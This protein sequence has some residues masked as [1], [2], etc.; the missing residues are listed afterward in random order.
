MKRRKKLEIAIILGLLLSQGM[1][2]NAWAE[3]LSGFSTLSKDYHYSTDSEYVVTGQITI[4]NGHTA[5]F[6]NKDGDNPVDNVTLNGGTGAAV[7][8]MA[9]GGKL[10]VNANDAIVVTSD[11]TFYAALSAGVDGTEYSLS[12]GTISISGNNLGSAILIGS[13]S[14]VN[15]KIDITAKGDAD[16]KVDTK[17]NT[18]TSKNSVAT[19]NVSAGITNITAEKGSNYIE[20][21]NNYGRGLYITTGAAKINVT[22]ENGKNIIETGHNAVEIQGDGA[23]I[24]LKGLS[25][26]IYSTNNGVAGV[27]VNRSNNGKITITATG[28]YVKGYGNNEIVGRETGVFVADSPKEEFN[29]V[30]LEAT[31]KNI[32]NQTKEMSDDKT[33][34]AGVYVGHGGSLSMTAREN[35]IK[36]VNEGV[37]GYLQSDITITATEGNNAI[38]AERS[39]IYVND[40][41]SH[42]D[43][44]S[45]IKLIAEKGDNIVQ[46]GKDA[47][48][49][50]GIFARYNS[51]VTLQAQNNIIE[52]ASVDGNR[53]GSGKAIATGLDSGDVV[54]DTTVTLEATEQNY[55]SGMVH[56]VAATTVNL[57]G[58]A[59]A[60]GNQA[61]VYN[62][63]RSSYVNSNGLQAVH[64]YDDAVINIDAGS[65][66]ERYNLIRTMS[67]TFDANNGI[68]RTVWAQRGANINIDGLSYIFAQNS[69]V[70]AAETEI[71]LDALDGNS[72]G[73][74]IT[75]GTG[76]EDEL[77]GYIQDGKL[78]DV[79]DADKSTVNVNYLGNSG[80]IGD[81]VSGFGGLV[82]VISKE[83]DGNLYLS[84]NA[85]AA[86]GG[87]AN[88]ELGVNGTW[89]GR[90]D[91]Y[92][93]ADDGHTTF[94]NPA[95]S[96][97]IID[98]GE[99]NLTMGDNST[100]FV[101][102][103]SWITSIDTTNA[104]NTTID[105]VSANTDHNTTAHALTIGELKGNTIFNMSLDGDRSVSDMLYIKEAHDGEYLVNLA[106]AV[107]TA[108]MYSD[109]VNTFTGLRFA[110]I[111]TGNATFRAVTYDDGFE[112]IEYL[113]AQD[114]YATSNENS[115]YNSADGSGVSNQEKPGDDSVDALFSD[116]AAG[117]N[118][119]NYKLVARKGEE[120]SDA[121]KT[122]LNMSR[123]NYSN[124]VYMDRLNKRLGEARY[125]NDEED[126][127][128]WVRIRHDRIGKTDAYR[129]QNTM[130]ELGYD[131]KQE[132]DNGKRRVGFALDYMHGDTGYDNIAGKG[133][134]DRYGVWLYDTWLGDK[135]HYADYVAKWGHLENDFEIYAPT[136]GEK[137][138]GD[139]CNNVLSISA[140]YGR[141]KD[142]GKD[143]YI[144]PQ[145][146]LQ[147][148]H[149]TDAGYTTSQNTAVQVDSINSLI[150]RLGFRLGKD[151]G[152]EKRSTVY[153]K[154]DILHEF[155]GDQDIHAMDRTTNGNWTTVS[156]ENKGTWYDVGFGYAAMLNK[157]SYAFIDLE[158]SF[159]HDNDE[160]YQINAGVQWSF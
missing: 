112:D 37:E 98:N 41:Y 116:S 68:E 159:G 71:D 20:N 32:I 43:Y 58:L 4:R 67:D 56:A 79:A 101:Q 8:A 85:L 45:N 51:E 42:D 108:E 130:Y 28:D 149:V 12:A 157:D 113:I 30:I 92:G 55:L 89:Y 9:G 143:W 69:G 102:G 117:L 81:I 19:V 54:N 40:K 114:D 21:T 141:K 99:V 48:N 120:L 52:A 18:L 5:E 66:K 3:N 106:D 38:N 44:M 46:A 87:I 27:Y 65:S 153:V 64:G 139:Y 146:Q 123:A 136:T 88:I 100:W 33:S 60:D 22:A 107:T 128:M 94:F 133:E 35:E 135:G 1:Y 17:V 23:E 151:F 97:Q 118:A 90:A 145:A 104:V 147:F 6:G 110:T 59:D 111:G 160:T 137:I 78:P 16:T 77:D 96:S 105:L 150:G 155:L 72:T 36:A 122:V 131:E 132:C 134:I 119:T 25:N 142:M 15:N 91:D 115:Y 47:N 49:S 50:S 127:G 70:S 129:S 103:Q 109:G 39:G 121:G 82:N 125:I 14:A 140:E 144:E 126:E 63:I 34:A 158:R 93:D 148:A 152:E 84:G 62:I 86:N 124:A 76:D 95:F 10:I 74:A 29:E 138:T 156:Y 80:I 13:P 73:V 53:Y 61:D 57:K 11:S 2:G 7:N 31:G 75:A 83:A 24:S 154:A 26:E